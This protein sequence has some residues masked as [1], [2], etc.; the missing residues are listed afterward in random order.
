MF[1]LQ[2]D[3]MLLFGDLHVNSR[4]VDRV[5]GS[6]QNR[7]SSNPDEKNLIFLWDYVYHFSYDREALLSL[8]N[9][10]LDNYRQGKN[11][12][13]LA[14]N[15][16]WLWNTFVFEEAK[17]TYEIIKNVFWDDWEWWKIEFITKPKIENIEW[18]NILFLPYCLELDKVDED[19]LSDSSVAAISHND[20]SII[21]VEN[22]IK[23][24]KD[25]KNKNERFSAKLNNF[26]LNNYKK[27]G[28]LTV[29]H[30]YYT[31]WLNF[32]WQKWKF[33][34]G[35]IALSKNF[36]D[37][38]WLKLISG[39]LHQW[40]AYKNY[41]CTGSTR[42]TSPLEIN[43][44]KILFQYSWNV[45]KWQPYFVNPYF[46]IENKWDENI[47]I[48]GEYIENFT[49]DVVGQNI[50]NY[51][52]SIFDIHINR[53]YDLRNKDISLFIKVDNVNYDEMYS[54]IDEA[55]FKDLKD[56]KMKKNFVKTEELFE[57]MDLEWKNLTS[58]FSDW[59]TLLK[60][61]I[62]AKYPWEYDKY[63]E[64][65]QNQKIL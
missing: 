50:S 5:I 20:S 43:Q 41:F 46:Q 59:K 15:H 1:Y 8:Y 34:F 39:H 57:K 31:E 11:V 29:I 3:T 37:L 2:Y 52:N 42:N 49:A 16:D 6:M 65:L 4:I 56:V 24:L 36:C 53:D 32:P 30:H 22:T 61:Y 10:F 33:H 38:E 40:F 55:L 51:D 48:D 47:K 17:R 23:I 64:F 7:I 54:Y 35:D 14:W 19:G 18:E 21:E 44:V 13:I 26:L 60:N 63:I 58:W 12:Y 9:F 25:S 27:H 28:E 62:S 45:L